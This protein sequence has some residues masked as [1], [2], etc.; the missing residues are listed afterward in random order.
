MYC[1]QFCM[2]NGKTVN[3]L[4][5]QLEIINVYHKLIDDNHCSFT[6]ENVEKFRKYIFSITVRVTEQE[7]DRKSSP[8]CINSTD[9]ECYWLSGKWSKRSHTHTQKPLAKR[10]TWSR[11]LGQISGL[12]QQIV[13]VMNLW[14]V[15]QTRGCRESERRLTAGQKVQCGSMERWH[16]WGPICSSDACV[17]VCFMVVCLITHVTEFVCVFVCVCSWSA[18]A[19]FIRPIQLQWDECLDLQPSAVK[20]MTLLKSCLLTSDQPVVSL[21][22]RQTY[23]PAGPGRLTHSM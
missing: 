9:Y 16:R 12:S 18:A 17:C 5:K 6:G 7:P 10:T 23:V 15:S 2:K 21:S 3:L 14:R 1:H 4:S 19:S 22:C 20:H 8:F 13:A 11:Y